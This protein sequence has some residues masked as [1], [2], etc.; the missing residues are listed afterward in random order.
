MHEGLLLGSTRARTCATSCPTLCTDEHL[1]HRSSQREERSQRATRQ[2]DEEQQHDDPV[3]GVL[4]DRDG[5]PRRQIGEHDVVAVQRRDRDR[6]KMA[7]RMLSW[8]MSATRFRK[9]PLSTPTRAMT[10]KTTANATATTTFAIGP[11]KATSAMD[12]RPPCSAAGFTITGFRPAEAS[13]HEHQRADGIEV[14]DRVERQAPHARGR[15]SPSS[16]AV[17]AWL[18]S[19]KVRPTSSATRPA[20]RRSIGR[21]RSASTSAAGGGHPAGS[22][23]SR[24]NL[25][26]SM[27]SSCDAPV[28]TSSVALFVIG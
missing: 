2:E 26:T 21:P 15:P 5:L 20:I 22:R 9:K 8:T 10:R 27:T 18:N 28:S 24:A 19:W 25:P 11:A 1:G 17:S 6:L 16:S 4:L 3:G 23:A 13:D 14:R 12:R 7:S